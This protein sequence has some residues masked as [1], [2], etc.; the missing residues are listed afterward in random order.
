MPTTMS[1]GS[2]YDNGFGSPIDDDRFDDD[3]PSSSHNRNNDHHHR[4][5]HRPASP[6][7]LED[8]SSDNSSQL[9]KNGNAVILKEFEAIKISRQYSNNQAKGSNKASVPAL[10]LDGVDWSGFSRAAHHPAEG[11]PRSSKRL[12][13]A[14]KDEILE[15]T[16]GNNDG[17]MQESTLR[18][19]QRKLSLEVGGPKTP[20][21]SSR[22]LSPGKYKSR[23]ASFRGLMVPSPSSPGAAGDG[24]GT[25]PLNDGRARGISS[26]R[27]ARASS[28]DRQ[29]RG[30]SRSRRSVE[31]LGGE[32]STHTSSHRSRRNL[33]NRS[34][35]P[36]DGV[37]GATPGAGEVQLCENGTSGLRKRRSTVR[38]GNPGESQDANNAAEN[39]N[40][41]SR[42]ERRFSTSKPR[43][44]RSLSS[45]AVRSAPAPRSERVPRKHRSA[46]VIDATRARESSASRSKSPKGKGLAAASAT[47]LEVGSR[48][49]STRTRRGS[50]GGLNMKEFA[51]NEIIA[52]KG[53]LRW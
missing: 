34:A 22:R 36:G 50:H 38:R 27:L 4:Q 20:A 9:I 33:R 45:G 35:T 5:L 40:R 43:K 53:S 39:P 10:T 8:D 12:Q 46:G 2:K 29:S 19:V 25:L 3:D 48:P 47:T 52:S 7:P 44:E 51:E 32:N 16:K 49:K 1:P 31:R 42:S 6:E 28:R 23:R 21:S 37:D 13:T 41:V 14:G 26:E 17:Q 15:L 18:L 24:G 11:R 30:T